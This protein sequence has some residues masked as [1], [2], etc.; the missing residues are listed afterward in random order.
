MLLVT[1][2]PSGEEGG[3]LEGCV[4]CEPRVTCSHRLRVSLTCREGG[5]MLADG[6]CD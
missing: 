2:R 3:W 1:V 6:I 4:G 5:F